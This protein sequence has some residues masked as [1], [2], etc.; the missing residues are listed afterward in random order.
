MASFGL[1]SL[2]GGSKTPIPVPVASTAAPASVGSGSQVSAAPAA[3]SHRPAGTAAPA[4]AAGRAAVDAAPSPLTLEAL[5]IA[6]AASVSEKAPGA[7]AADGSGGGGKR[8]PSTMR[9][10][11]VRSLMDWMTLARCSPE[12]ILAQQTATDGALRVAVCTAPAP[13]YTAPVIRTLGEAFLT[14]FILGD[15]RKVAATL[16]F[17][18]GVVG[19]PK[20]K[21]LN[22]GA[23]W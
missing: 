6:I 21:D 12:G 2:I 18:A 9:K 17:L 14:N 16:D 7:H 1:R 20:A 13:V 19:G 8:G 15:G 22:S 10:A 11:L 23:K 3:A 4:V 5:A